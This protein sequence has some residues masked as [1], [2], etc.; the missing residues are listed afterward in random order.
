MVIIKKAS[1][2]LASFREDLLVFTGP[3]EPDGA[4]TYSLYDPLKGQYYQITWG[5][6]L[7]MRVFK[8][9]MT[10]E[11]LVNEVNNRSSL[12]VSEQDIIN[13]FNEAYSLNLL[14]IH[15]GSEEIEKIKRERK[16]GWA[17]W[18]LTHYLYIRIP[19]VNPDNF[20]QAT[21]PYVRP[22]ISKK[23]L[24]V[25]VFLIFFGLFNIVLNFDRY[26]H[27]FTYFFNI[28]GLIAYAL[29]IIFVKILHELGHAYTAKYYNVHVPTLGVAFLVL[30]PVL[31]TNVTDAWKLKK[32]RERFAISAAGVIVELFIAGLATIG[33]ALTDPG[34]LNSV[35]FIISS[36]TWVTTLFLNLNP[37]MRFDGYY[38]LTDLLGIDNLQPRSFAVARWKLREWFLGLNAPCPEDDLP[39]KTVK[40]MVVYSIY[41]WIYRLV[42]YTSIAIF[43]YFLFT[44]VL[45]IILFIVEV[46]VFIVAPFGSEIKQLFRQR[47]YFKINYRLILTVIFLSLIVLWFILPLPRDY[48]FSGITAAEVK[49]D[50]YVPESSY[51]SKVYVHRGQEVKKDQIL[52][53][54]TSKKL[55]KAKEA[56]EAEIKMLSKE[57]E[58]LGLTE[59]NLKYLTTKEAELTR[60]MSELD[61]LNEK[62]NKLTVRADIDGVL[63]EWE[64]TIRP[65]LY[66]SKG[67]ILGKIAQLNKMMVITY[68]PENRI[69]CIEKG[70]DV[71][72]KLLNPIE[73][74][75][76]KIREVYSAPAAF[77]HYPVLASIYSGSLPVTAEKKPATSD[78]KLKLNGTFYE[79]E[80]AVD[81]D[82]YPLRFGKSGE[83]EVQGPPESKLWV[84]IQKLKGV[85]WKESGF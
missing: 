83:V 37:A 56:T 73:R 63:F 66:I 45:G 62:L 55:E 19:L 61:I 1:P 28:Q 74:F 9:G 69:E 33:W 78:R 40:M 39:P 58:V 10:L 77:L 8:P 65:D 71:T 76:G 67:S 38:L 68:V 64:D 6:A 5:Q 60:K 15:K 46:A 59:E 27:T 3:F 41:T 35:F 36:V 85:F 43:V 23:A 22:L 57:I 26:I 79:V 75:K 17:W 49:Q 29:A 12:R 24:F 4:P 34:M 80:V 84:L 21:L 72:F 51:I 20:L 14:D 30:W 82:N 13:I 18:L 2:I 31:Y 50:I 42:L 32:R 52:V 48:Y 54:L 81:P 11:A 70:A 53:E 47:D 7:V 44:K 25:Y 16:I